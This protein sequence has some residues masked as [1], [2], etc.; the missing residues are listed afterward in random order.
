MLISIIPSEVFLQYQS[1]FMTDRIFSITITL[2]IAMLFV[3]GTA[4]A[5]FPQTVMVDYY[6]TGTQNPNVST[7]APLQT[8]VDYTIRIE[9]SF[10]NIFPSSYTNPC[11]LNAP[12]FPSPSAPGNGPVN[13]DA[14][15]TINSHT[16]A[17]CG[18]L[19]SP[20]NI[21]GYRLSNSGGYFGL[22]A[23]IPY[24]S[25][26]VYTI[27]VTGQGDPINFRLSDPGTKLDNYGQVAMTVSL[28]STPTVPTLSQ[29]G[30]ILLALV[31]LNIGA[32]VLLIRQRKSSPA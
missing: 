1:T 8:G 24:S 22:P 16:G 9:G 10:S 18:S 17:N 23:S 19:P 6:N 21:W 15:F 27:T 25:Q 2:A 7:S 32:V 11:V 30:M 31:I 13:F 3:S 20:F 14:G 26:H 29:W 5:Q 4:F 12:I 28:A